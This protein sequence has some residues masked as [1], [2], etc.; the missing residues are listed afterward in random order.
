[1]ETCFGT[2]HPKAVAT[3]VDDSEQMLAF[4][5]SPPSTGCISRRAIPSN[6]TAVM[7]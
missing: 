3:I 4:Y 7:R 2:K 5:D 6:P 1:L